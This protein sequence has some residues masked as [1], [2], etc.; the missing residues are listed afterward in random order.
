[1]PGGRGGTPARPPVAPTT[2]EYLLMGDATRGAGEAKI[3]VDPTNPKNIVAI[4]MG[5]LQV[6]PGYK[7][8]VTAGMTDKYHE[9]NRSDDPLARGDARRRHDL[10][11]RRTSDSLREEHSLPRS[12]RGRHEGRRLPGRLRTPRNDGRVLWRLGGYDLPGQG[13]HVGQ[14]TEIVSSYSQAR[15]APGLKPRIGGNWRLGTVPISTST[16]QRERSTPKRPAA[17]PTSTRERRGNTGPSPTSPPQPMGARAQEQ[18]TRSTRS[19]IRRA[20]VAPSQRVTA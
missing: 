7:P 14:A 20:A 4:S 19:N 11:G 12:L 10:E 17:R 16:M 6:L 5:N 2:E 13:R 15:F 1:M 3:A 9:V 18:S 8:P